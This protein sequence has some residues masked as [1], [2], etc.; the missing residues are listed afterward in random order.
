MTG[1]EPTARISSPR[2]PVHTGSGDQHNYNWVIGANEGLVRTGIARLEIVREH[3][4]RLA[5][6][7]V[8]PP[9][10]RQAADRL[11]PPGT[12]VL[13]NGPAGAGRRSAAT[14]LLAGASADDGRVEEL[15][16]NWEEDT[17]DFDASEDGRYLLDLSGVTDADY[18]ATQRTLTRYRARVEQ[19][20]ARMVAVTPA[21]L[22][23]MLD[24]DLSPLVVSLERPRGRA[25]L[26]RYLRVR[27]VAFDPEQLVTDDLTHLFTTAPVRELARLGELIVE[28][29][30][31]KRYGLRFEDWRD[32]AVAAATNW[33]DEVSRSMRQHRSVAERALLLTAAMTSGA[34]AETVLNSTSVLL[35]VLRHEPDETPRLAQA[36]IGEQ[37]ETLSL[38]RAEDGKVRFRRLAYDRAVRRHFWENF[39]DLRESFRDWVGRCLTEVPD[40]RTEERTRLVARFAEQALASGR[41]DDLCVL[42]E[43]WTDTAAG[44]RLRAAAAAALELGLSHD[45]YGSRFRSRVYDW[46]T[47]V[48]ISPDL[49]RVLIDVCDQV[50]AE[51]HPEQAMVRLR[52]LVLRHAATERDAAAART[53]LLRLARSRTRL[54]RRL[55]QRLLFREGSTDQGTDIVLALLEPAE[56]RITPPWPEFTRAWRA[57]MTAKPAAVWTSLARHWL[58]ALVENRADERALTALLVAAWSDQE[59][60]DLLYV[61]A[62]EWAGQGPAGASEGAR[63]PR[64]LRFRIAEELC[65]RIDTVQGVAG[66]P[67]PSDTWKTR[68]NS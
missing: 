45:V 12:V 51:T 50:M 2:G 66:V 1:T 13:L 5:R 62:C 64:G 3:R 68:K 23:W 16:L 52:H 8:R 42:V 33:A 36:D 25:V 61:T 35:D 14:M 43:K 58:T 60:L 17:S 67:S 10:Y 27:G 21:G 55:L 7:F 65:G 6:C 44:G 11:V 28:A 40:L 47:A 4:R 30:N 32:E 37:L 41:P 46:V 49:A 56:L 54:Y 63:A 26:S 39:P 57:V 22:D 20:G 38:E 18:P 15:P 24:P 53:A 31:S 29:R 9:G 19:C 59:T 48:R 34:S